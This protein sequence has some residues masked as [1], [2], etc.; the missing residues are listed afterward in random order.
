MGPLWVISPL[1][2]G[3]TYGVPSLSLWALRR[4]PAGRSNGLTFPADPPNGVV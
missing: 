2:V 4:V 3:H 1:R